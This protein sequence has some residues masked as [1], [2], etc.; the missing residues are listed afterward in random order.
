MF[1]LFSKLLERKPSCI[2]QPTATAT[3]LSHEE[4]AH[5]PTLSPSW[6]QAEQ[7]CR[8]RGPHA[9]LSK[10]RPPGPSRPAPAASFCGRPPQTPPAA[11]SPPPS[12]AAPLHP[13]ACRLPVAGT[14]EPLLLP[15]H[16]HS[17]ARASGHS[18]VQATQGLQWAPHP[19][20]R[21]GSRPREALTCRGAGW[22]R[23]TSSHPWP[24]A[25]PLS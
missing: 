10:A 20:G 19:H 23:R 4:A 8:T 6:G 11:L 22:P 14:T 5:Y 7:P 2:M 13:T 17:A 21:R 16:S 15:F 24:S 3:P 18:R 9:P 1:Q 25:P 12:T